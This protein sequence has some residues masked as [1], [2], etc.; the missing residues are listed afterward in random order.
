[1]AVM[2]V[3]DTGSGIP[4]SMLPD[5]FQ[6]FTQ[7]EESLDRNRGGLGLGLALVKGIAEMHGGREHQRDRP[8]PHRFR[9]LRRW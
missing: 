6:P 8:A 4:D 5:L 7:A 3:R 1:M 9:G 2:W